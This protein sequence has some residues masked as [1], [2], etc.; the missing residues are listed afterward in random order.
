[1]P[2]SVPS[3]RLVKYQTLL[4]ILWSRDSHFPHFT[5]GKTEPLRCKW[6]A[7]GLW[8]SKK[9]PAV[10]AGICTLDPGP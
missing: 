2:A 1:M 4:T 3:S 7:S 9:E 6:F 8:G 5:Y 10:K